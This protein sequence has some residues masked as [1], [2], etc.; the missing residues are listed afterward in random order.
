[1]MKIVAAVLLCLGC[2]SVGGADTI[3][4]SFSVADGFTSR[5]FDPVTLTEG[6]FSATF[7]GGFREAS[8][9]GPAYNTGPDAYFFLNGS[10]FTGSFNTRPI[11]SSTDVGT[12]DFNIGV[13]E[14]SFFAVDRANGTP[15]LRI[16]GVDGSV[17]AS[18]L[19]TET[20][21]RNA[22]AQ[23]SFSSSDLGALIGGIEFDN[24]GPAGNP[25]YVIA[26]DT[27]SATAVPEPTSFALMA[28]FGATTLG[29]RRRRS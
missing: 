6:N 10:N 17:L 19:I 8:F 7:D 3:S 5:S 22:A 16:L 24:A 26:I 14:L 12:V 18:E 28:L 29:V 13:T 9:D 23:F 21:N 20:N 27:F 4:T 2:A 11:S 25:P 1:M 15:S